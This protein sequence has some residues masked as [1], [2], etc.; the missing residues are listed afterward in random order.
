MPRGQGFFKFKADNFSVLGSAMQKHKQFNLFYFNKLLLVFAIMLAQYVSGYAQ[1][2]SIF[3]DNIS[4]KPYYFYKGDKCGS[5]GVF[6][7]L[8]L[9]LNTGYDICQLT[10]HDRQIL[11]FPYDRSTENVFWNLG[12]PVKV[13]DEIGWWQFTKTEVLPLSFSRE[14]GQWMPNYVLHLIGGGMSYATVSE[15]YRFHN[16]DYAKPL[17]FITLM[18]ADFLNEIMENNAYMGSNI[19]PIPDVYIFNLAGVALFSSEKVCRF[20]SEELQ[21]ADWSLQPSIAFSDLSLYNCGQYFSFKWDIPFEPRLALFTR[22]GLGTLIGLS[23]KFQN[24]TSISAGAGVRSGEQYLLP[25]TAR[26]VTITTPFSFGVFYDKNNSLLASVQYSNVS[27]YFINTNIYPGLIKIGKFS[28][29]IW[30]VIDK[31][32]YPVI[33]I[34]SRYTLG[35]G[36]GYNFRKPL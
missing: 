2:D 34:T 9:V 27:D 17:G 22:M 33:G 13:I 18:A 36:L 23:W 24:E 11:K 21:M 15:W 14:G 1:N 6:N 28:P 4:E 3:E 29:G 26:E 8:T 10:E 16:V 30:A 19:D 35:T 32:G 7:P 12:H 5:Q 25:G 20:F 31:K